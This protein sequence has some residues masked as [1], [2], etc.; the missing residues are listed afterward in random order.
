M[1]LPTVDE[2][3]TAATEEEILA[4]I[5][6]FAA[7]LGLPVTSWFVFGVARTI[8]VIVSKVVAPLTRVLVLITKGGFLDTATGSWLKLLAFYYYAVSAQPATPA[9]GAV[10]ITS[11][12]G[13]SVLYAIGELSFAHEDTGKT[14]RNSA[15]VTIPPTGDVTFDIVADEAGTGSNASADKI[16][17]C[18]NGINGI[19]VTNADV[20][21]GEDEE[22]EASIRARCRLRL[23]AL[24]PLGPA[25]VYEYVALTQELNGGV[26]INRV[27]VT[28]N[29][30]T[31]VV[32]VD[33]A[34]AGGAPT[35]PEV[36]LVNA[37]L[38]KWALPLT[39]TLFT[40]A[41]VENTIAIEYT[42]Y[43][44]TDEN[45]TTGEIDTLIASALATYFSKLPIGG[46]VL[47]VVPGHV[48]VNALEG[49]IKKA[50]PL[51]QISVTTPAADVVIATNEV[52]KLGVITPHTTLV[53]T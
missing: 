13:D 22:S 12:T 48:F 8:C 49:E 41:A 42:A 2:L 27:K 30:T 7:M 14:Y 53:D 36:A 21:L 52:P 43:A 50:A 19:E 34:T 26:A 10:T 5:L 32:R 4:L 25:Q 1:A 40:L 24:S 29:S 16:T 44:S 20:V 39:N 18:L 51:I 23:A 46:Y 28:P 6:S 15:A 17:I 9:T 3:V 11:T 31:G 38:V 47:T 35:T 45:L 37:G 33:L